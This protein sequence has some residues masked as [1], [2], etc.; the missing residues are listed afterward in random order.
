MNV[1]KK[2]REKKSSRNELLDF[3]IRNKTKEGK[4]VVG[5]GWRASTAL[6]RRT[7]LHGELWHAYCLF[8]SLILP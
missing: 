4:K 7:A 8:S 6:Q 3:K 2:K 5:M 1:K